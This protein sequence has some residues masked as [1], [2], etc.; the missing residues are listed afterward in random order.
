MKK[1]K[2][3]MKIMKELEN[4]REQY[5]YCNYNHLD[6]VEA[7]WYHL[8]RLEGAQKVLEEDS[9]SKAKEAFEEL[10]A[11]YEKDSCCNYNADM[12]SI[13]DYWHRLGRYEGAEMMLDALEE[14]NK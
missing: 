8:G 11:A 3:T 12:G 1:S 10:K 14:E 9:F 6:Y 2:K 7:Y 5:P 13:E 4:K